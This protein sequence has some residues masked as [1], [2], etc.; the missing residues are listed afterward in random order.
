MGRSNN[1][2]LSDNQVL[3]S[4]AYSTDVETIDI[5][6]SSYNFVEDGTG[7]L[8]YYIRCLTGTKVEVK[9]RNEQDPTNLEQIILPVSNSMV[10]QPNV[11]EIVFGANT[12]LTGVT[13]GY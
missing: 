1:N 10:V 5:S 7:K 11:L 12:D 6:L 9:V 2:N 13:V 3:N 4:I 8:P